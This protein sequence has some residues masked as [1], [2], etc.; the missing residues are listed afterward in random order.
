[1]KKL[2]AALVSLTLLCS[3]GTGQSYETETTVSI[4][5]TTSAQVQRTET[6]AS[7]AE[8]TSQAAQTETE[9]DEYEYQPPRE[10]LDTRFYSDDIEAEIKWES[11]LTEDMKDKVDWDYISTDDMPEFIIEDILKYGLENSEYA[12][13]YSDKYGEPSHG[14]GYMMYDM[15]S[16]GLDDYI[17]KCGVRY[18]WNTDGESFYKIY[19]TGEDGSYTPIIWDCVEQFRPTQY[20]LKT[21]TNGLKDIFVFTNSNEPALKYDG[22]SAYGGAAELD[23]RHTFLS[24]EILPG[25]VLRLNMNISVISAETGEYYAA[26]KFADN[27]Y[28]KN[29]MLYTCDHDGTPRTY[30]EKPYGEH[31]DF[32]PAVQGYDFYVELTDEGVKAFSEEDNV[33]QLLD[34]L[35]IKYIPAETAAETASAER[36]AMEAGYCSFDEAELLSESDVIAIAEKFGDGFKQSD[37]INDYAEIDDMGIPFD[38]N[39]GIEI[40]PEGVDFE[41]YCADEKNFPMYYED[42]HEN[43]VIEKLGENELYSQWRNGYTEIRRTYQNDVPTVLELDREYRQVFLKNF[44]RNENNAFSYTGKMT[45]EDIARNFDIF[46]KSSGEVKICRR[47]VETDDSFK[48]EFYCVKKVGGDW[49]LNDEAVIE[50]RSVE[51]SKADGSFCSDGITFYR[52]GFEIPGTAHEMA[53]ERED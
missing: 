18:I 6:T 14:F 13:V 15:N 12:K 51:I 35:E 43:G 7:I 29:N 32:S 3:C 26:I 48:Y 25:N 45:A 19:L 50:G 4:A 1:M 49:G 22:V 53:W 46:K 30:T 38:G 10:V 5:E 31:N 21:K 20:I 9:Y 37:F 23:E 33:W 11:I 34:L 47:V 2:F 41:E 17:V 52:A 39:F 36:I 44:A 24:G 27:T 28:L 42:E 40:V 16:D 8:T